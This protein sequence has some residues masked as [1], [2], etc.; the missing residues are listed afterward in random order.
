MDAIRKQRVLILVVACH[1]ESTIVDVVRRIPVALLDEY[2]FELLIIDDSSKHATFERSHAP[3][4]QTALPFDVQVLFNPVNRGYGCS[5][6]LGYHYAIEN[7]FDFVT[8][9]HDDGQFAPG[10][11]LQ[12]RRPLTEGGAAAVF[13]SR[14]IT[15]KGAIK[16]GMA[17]QTAPYA[18]RWLSASK[19]YTRR[20]DV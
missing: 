2:D 14:M 3:S 11:P 7:G 18:G 9:L 15:P 10:C 17:I 12:L 4:L 6:T 20:P 5:Q 1:T 13:G 19:P 16:G 8:L